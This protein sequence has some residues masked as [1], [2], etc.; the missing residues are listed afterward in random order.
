MKESQSKDLD[1]VK[2]LEVQID[3]I[4]AKRDEL[5]KIS[6]EQNQNLSKLEKR[7]IEY[8]ETEK[9]NVQKHKKQLKTIDEEKQKQ[10]QDRTWIGNFSHDVSKQKQES[11]EL[12]SKLEFEAEKLTEIQT[13]LGPK[14]L[15]Y[16]QQIEEKQKELAP[17]LAK[18]NTETGTVRVLE[19]EHSLLSEKL[20]KSK[21]DLKI[22]VETES[23]TKEL[24]LTSQTNFKTLTQTLKESKLSKTD[25]EKQKTKSEKELEKIRQ[26]YLEL[27]SKSHDQKM[28]AQQ[29]KSSSQVYQKLLIQ[30]QQNSIKGIH[31]RLGDLGTIDKKYDIAITTSCGQL[32]SIVCERVETAQ[33][34]IKYLKDHKLGR[35]T[36]LCLDKISKKDTRKVDTPE[37]VPRIFDL[38][39][40][41]DKFKDVFYQALGDTLVA[42]NLEQANRVAYGKTRYK[43]VTLDGQVIDKSGTISGGGNRVL[44]G[45]MS[46]QKQ[47]TEELLDGALD[48]SKEKFESKEI[49]VLKLQEKY[50]QCCLEYDDLKNQAERLAME[51][52]SIND[53]LEDCVNSVRLAKE[54][55][56]IPDEEKK[57]M[58][59]LEKLLGTHRE[60]LETLQNSSKTIEDELFKLHETIME[61]GGVKLRLQNAKV[62]SINEQILGLQKSIMQLTAEKQTREK[63]FKKSLDSISKKE[64]EADQLELDIE[65]KKKEYQEMMSGVEEL[66]VRVKKASDDYELLDDDLKEA[67]ETLSEKMKEGNKIRQAQVEF[68]AE[69]KKLALIQQQN[70][71]AIKKYKQELSSLSIQITGFEQEET[72][73][74]EFGEMELNEM[75]LQKLTKE[76]E[77][78]SKNHKG[79]PPNLAVLNEYKQKIQRMSQHSAL[80]EQST[81]AR[82][83]KKDTYETLRKTRLEEFMK[84]FREI[85]LKLKEMYKMITMGG[86]A[87]LELVD[88]LDPF[89]EGVLF[90]VMPPKKS[91]K[92][93]SNLSGG[94]KVF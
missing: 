76:Y 67:K 12:K 48:E 92:N 60:K 22:A 16:Q 17:W 70:E 41:E 28:L 84:G 42:K 45:G 20:E 40:C 15:I 31:A 37:G 77:S 65:A 10:N 5:K 80:V 54:N 21:S 69:L 1:K 3:E 72:L 94:E 74:P 39:D 66:K 93:I 91:W 79:Q 58:K 34:C 35:A 61:I 75:D 89:S 32:D 8:K 68:T 85:S 83:S 87:E 7:E 27:K 9:F 4:Q 26:E 50:E 11:D 47:D 29:Q 78:L 81:L 88:S 52:K 14:T 30:K 23:E 25:L 24:L 73:I 90:S 55:S 51:I 13:S 62:D 64:S 36:F 6:K 53:S 59:E 46:S 44:K 33:E 18:I 63:H 56:V 38:I 19:S 2:E 43:V 71:Q 57:R 82:N 86:N 49:E